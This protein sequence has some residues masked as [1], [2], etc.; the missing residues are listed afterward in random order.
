MINNYREKS[1]I[2]TK[3]FQSLKNSLFV[4]PSEIPNKVGPSIFKILSLIL[5]GRLTLILI[6]ITL[7]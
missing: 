7:Q 1:N 4:S 5:T 2:L 3:G 6:L